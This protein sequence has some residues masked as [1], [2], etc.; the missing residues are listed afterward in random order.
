MGRR[1]KTFCV[2]I[3]GTL[4]STTKDQKYHEAKPFVHMID[5]INKLYDAGHTIKLLTARGMGSGKNFEEITKKQIKEWGVKH[6]SLEFGKPSAD[7]YL[8]DKALTIDDFITIC[9]TTNGF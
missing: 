9:E 3:D 2:D 4:C 8:D 7:Y 5:R 1:M 6:H